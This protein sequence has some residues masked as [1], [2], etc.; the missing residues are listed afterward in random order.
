MPD[1]GSLLD[2]RS[3]CFIARCGGSATVTMRRFAL[4][5]ERIA[6]DQ[7]VQAQMFGQVSHPGDQG[8]PKHEERGDGD[9]PG[10]EWAPGGPA[11][12][13]DVNDVGDDQIPRP[14]T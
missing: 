13:L 11:G 10:D 7:S 3:R 5:T 1:D 8:K 2:H 14:D 4:P 12:E 9:V 6:I